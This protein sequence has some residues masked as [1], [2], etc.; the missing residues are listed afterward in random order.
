MAPFFVALMLFRNAI[1]PQ[2]WEPFQFPTKN[3]TLSMSHRDGIF[4]DVKTDE[5]R[6]SLSHG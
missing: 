1:K 5:K 6:S 4:V 2:G 3:R